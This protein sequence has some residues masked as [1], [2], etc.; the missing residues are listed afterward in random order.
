MKTMWEI[1]SRTV[2]RMPNNPF[3]GTRNPAKEGKPYEWKTW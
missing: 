1:Y 3:L 2:R